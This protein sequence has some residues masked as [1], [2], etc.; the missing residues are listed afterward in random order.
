MFGEILEQFSLLVKVLVPIMQK[1]VIISCFLERNQMT[2]SANLKAKHENRLYVSKYC[3]YSKVHD[4]SVK[5]E[6][7]S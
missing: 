6:L 1:I 7:W 5:H 4:V 2:V 3:F